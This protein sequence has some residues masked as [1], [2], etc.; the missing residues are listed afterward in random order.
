MLTASSKLLAENM[1]S[2]LF[3]SACFHMRTGSCTSITVT[4]TRT[5]SLLAQSL[6]ADNRV[7]QVFLFGVT[8]CRVC[9]RVQLGLHPYYML[10]SAFHYAWWL[11]LTDEQEFF[12]LYFT[13]DF[14]RSCWLRDDTPFF[15][16]SSGPEQE[17]CGIM[18]LK[19]SADSSLLCIIL[20][21]CTWWTRCTR[22]HAHRK[23]RMIDMKRLV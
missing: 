10:Y 11:E 9:V 17:P 23:R 19:L 1:K 18:C 13:D 8:D 3:K 7:S 22:K 4:H 16:I 15:I 2:S 12:P 6:L 21:G 20:T 14:Y 5:H